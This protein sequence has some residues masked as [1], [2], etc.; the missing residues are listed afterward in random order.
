MRYQSSGC[1]SCNMF[2]TIPI[3]F[4]YSWS[5]RRFSTA[6]SR[7]KYRPRYITISVVV[8][9]R[10][11]IV[12]GR[13][14]V[15]DKLYHV[16]SCLI[17]ARWLDDRRELHSLFCSKSHLYRAT[18]DAPVVLIS[19]KITN[20]RLCDGFDVRTRYSRLIAFYN[21]ARSDVRFAQESAW[22]SRARSLVFRGVMNAINISVLYNMIFTIFMP[23]LCYKKYHNTRK[24]FEKL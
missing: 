13:Y 24:K 19:S 14:G 8:K 21:H 16:D 9:H 23:F 12:F 1:P 17:S 5:D 10:K 15:Y 7:G 11:N 2:D 4:G 22:I 6:I 20:T 3:V 18:P